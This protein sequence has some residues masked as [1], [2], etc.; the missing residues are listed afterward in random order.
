M[1]VLIIF[2]MRKK[3]TVSHFEFFFK[4]CSVHMLHILASSSPEMKQLCDTWKIEL[5]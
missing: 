1:V 2:L 5:D 3:L 4:Q